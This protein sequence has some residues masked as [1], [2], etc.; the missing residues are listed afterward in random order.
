ML[1]LF[2]EFK[3]EN[4]R[5]FN[6]LQDMFEALKDSKEKS[7][8]NPTDK[9]WKDFYDKSMLSYFWW[10]TEDELIRYIKELKFASKEQIHRDDSLIR[11]WCFTFLL[12]S[13]AKGEYELSSCKIVRENVGRLEFMTWSW[14]YKGAGSLKALVESFGFEI[15]K[16]EV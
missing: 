13:I 3:V 6:R 16:N 15:I 7:Q 5:N 9:K 2:I 12:E 8:L 4:S 11:P 10:P 14:P 1:E